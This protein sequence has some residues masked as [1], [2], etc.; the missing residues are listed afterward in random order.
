MPTYEYKIRDKFGNFITGIIEGPS[1]EEVIRGL[2]SIGHEIV[3]IEERKGIKIYLYDLFGKLQKV[4]QIEIIDFIRQLSVMVRSGL[5]IITALS[6]ISEQTRNEKLKTVIDEIRIDIEGGSS[7][8][9]A[10]EKHPRVFSK[11]FASMIRT[12]E[13][14][15]ILSEVLDRLALIGRGEASFRAKISTAMIYP[16]VLV[17]VAIAVVIGL[18]VGVLPKFI[19]IFEEAGAKLPRPTIILLFISTVLRRFWYLFVILISVAVYV[20]VRY[21]KT[22]EGRYKLHEILLKTPLIKDLFLKIAIARFA[23]TASALLKSGVPIL[24]ALE[25]SH[26]VVANDVLARVIDDTKRELAAGKPLTEP[27]GKS[28][29][30]PPMVIQ[31]VTVGEQ[32]GRLDEMLREVGEFYEE[33]VAHTVDKITALLEPALLLSMGV[34]VGFIALSVL[35]PI[36]NLVKVFRH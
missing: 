15:G 30:F 12:G 3:S 14:A 7:F 1:R 16:V 5:P 33:E 11:F 13:T 6:S 25:V 8:S 4:S 31:M 17:T 32:T 18:L 2:R 22:E 34:M 20:S 10:L 19:L 23:Q 21:F 24:K 9:E 27:L 35:L 28:G 29:I 36:F 26:D